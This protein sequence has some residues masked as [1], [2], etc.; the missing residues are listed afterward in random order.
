M[1]EKY[2]ELYKFFN[3]NALTDLDEQQFYDAYSGESKYLDIYRFML[4]NNMTD[5]GPESF[6]DSYFKKKSEVPEIPSTALSTPQDQEQPTDSVYQGTQLTSRDNTILDSI[7]R[8]ELDLLPHLSDSLWNDRQLAKIDNMESLDKPVKP[9]LIEVAKNIK[10]ESPYTAKALGLISSIPIVGEF[11]DDVSREV[12]AGVT[13]DGTTVEQNMGI[14]YKMLASEDVTMRDVDILLSDEKRRAEFEEKYGKSD[15]QI[16][17]EKMIAEDDSWSSNLLYYIQNPELGA[18]QAFRSQAALL[19]TK[20][21][22]AFGSVVAASMAAG[23]AI[24]AGL[25]GT[26]SAGVLALPGAAGGA[27]VGGAGSIIPAYALANGINELSLSFSDMIGLELDRLGL[28]RTEENILRVLNSDESRRNILRDSGTRGLAITMVDVL[29]GKFAEGVT[30]KMLEKGTRI[31]PTVG[32]GL[33]IEGTAGGVGEATARGLVGQELT[34]SDILA[35]A[36]GE[37]GGFVASG[38]APLIDAYSKRA[39]LRRSG[40]IPNGKAA[41]SYFVGDNEVTAE[42]FVETIISANEEQL[43]N[44]NIRVENDPAMSNFVQDR[45][46][47]EGIKSTIDSSIS[48]ED[49]NDIA[50]LEM[51]KAKVMSNIK[52]GEDAYKHGEITKK[53]VE[54]IDNQILEIL[55]KYDKPQEDKTISQDDV[56]SEQ[57]AEVQ[58]MEERRV[59]RDAAQQEA[60]EER[61]RQ[62]EEEGRVDEAEDLEPA[63]ER[64]SLVY[65]TDEARKAAREAAPAT[66]T[67]AVS[68]N[69]GQTYEIEYGAEGQ[70]KKVQG[71]LVQEGNKVSLESFDG[72]QIIELGSNDEVADASVKSLGLSPVSPPVVANNDGSFVVNGKTFVNPNENASDAITRNDDGDVVNVQLQ[73]EDGKRR[74]FRGTNADAIAYEIALAQM[75]TET[76][77][78]QLE[79]L[80]NEDEGTKEAFDKAR[81]SEQD[82]TQEADT[83]TQQD[84]QATPEQPVTEEGK[85]WFEE[86]RRAKE[87]AE[88]VKKE[89]SKQTEQKAVADA[90]RNKKV[91]LKQFPLVRDKRTGKL[92]RRVGGPFTFEGNKNL[93]R[94]VPDGKPLFVDESGTYRPSETEQNDMT[95]V[96]SSESLFETIVD[97]KKATETKKPT[98][99]KTESQREV[100]QSQ[101][102]IESIELEIEDVQQEID[103]EKGNYKEAMAGF[104][105]RIA[106]IRANKE[107]SKEEKQEAIDDIKEGEMVDYKDD[108]DGII[109]SYKDDISRLKKDLAAEK[110]RLKKL[111]GPQ[112][113]QQSGTREGT[114]D[115]DANQKRRVVKAKSMKDLLKI[116]MELFGLD[117]EKALYA[118]IIAD[119]MIGA[120]AIRSGKSKAQVYNSISWTDTED[121]TKSNDHASVQYQE[122]LTNIASGNQRLMLFDS[123]EFQQFVR[124]GRVTVGEKSISDFDGSVVF[125][126]PDGMFA[127][128]ITSNGREVVKGEGG[129][130]YP[131]VFS[132]ENYF[133]ASTKGTTTTLVNT[134][135]EAARRST[136]GKVRFALT[137]GTLTKVFS[138]TN[139]SRGIVQLFAEKALNAKIPLAQQLFKNAL[140]EANYKVGYKS[141][142][143]ITAQGKRLIDA[144]KA[145]ENLTSEQK[146]SKIKEIKSD[147]ANAYRERIPYKLGADIKKSM[148][149][150]DMIA[151]ILDKLDPDNSSFDDR[152]WFTEKLIGNIVDSINAKKNEA[153][154]QY[155]AN[156]FSDFSGLESVIATNTKSYTKLNIKDVQSAIARSIQEKFINQ[157]Y[158]DGAQ[159]GVTYAVIEVDVNP[160]G[161]TFRAVDTKAE[162]RRSHDSYPFAVETVNGAKPV[163]HLLSDAK[164]YYDVA[165]E[166]G[167]NAPVGKHSKTLY[168]TSGLSKVLEFYHNKTM[169]LAQ[170][171]KYEDNSGTT[172]VAT[173]TGSYTKAAKKL[174][175]SNPES[176]L[177]YGA[178]L[179][180]G[181][182]AMSD[183]FG[184][185]VDSYEPNPERWKGRR[186]ATFAGQA[187]I[188]K[189]YD[190]IVSLNVLNVVPKFI[191][192]RIVTDIYNKLNN[193]GKAYISARKFKGDVANAKNSVKGDEHNSLVITR[194]QGGQDVE[195][196]QKGFDGDEL[197]NYIQGLL[198]DKVEVKKDNS[199]GASGVVITR[200]SDE[201]VT[202][203]SILFQDARAA[204]VIEDMKAV[205]YAI[206]NPDVTS[207]LHELSHLFE[208]Y[209]TDE[210][211]QAVLDW[212][213]HEEWSRDTSEAFADGF[214]RFLFQGPSEKIPEL[215]NVFQKFKQWVMEIY[216]GIKNSPMSRELNEPMTRIYESMV[217]AAEPTNVTHDATNEAPFETRQ[218][219]WFQNTMDTLNIR[220]AE[221]YW[222]IFMLQDDIERFR[223]KLPKRQNFKAAED[224]MHGRTRE[225]IV[226]MEKILDQAVDLMKRYKLDSFDVGQYLLALHA[227]ER[228]EKI[229]FDQV[230]KGIEEPNEAG[231]GM[232]TEEARRILS[233]LRLNPEKL[234][235]L[236][237][238][239]SLIRKIQDQTR[240]NLVAYGLEPEGRVASWSEMFSEYIP[241]H[242]FALDEMNTLELESETG[243]PNG[244]TGLH[245]ASPIVKKAK[246]RT[247]TAVNP[248]ATVV[249]QAQ[250]VIVAGEKNRALTAMFNLIN[251]NPNEEFWRIT[252]KEKGDHTVAV[253]ING[254]KVYMYFE[255]KDYAKTI[256]NTG[257]EK[258]SFISKMLRATNTWLRRA[259]TTLDPEFAITNFARDIQSAVINALSETDV[260]DLDGVKLAKGIMKRTTGKNGTLRALL[261]HNRG[262]TSG[263]DKM[264]TYINEFEMLGGKTGWSHVM[265]LEQIADDLKYKLDELS[266]SR[267]IMKRAGTPL[268]FVTKL[269]EDVNDAFENSIRL[270]SYITAVESGVSKE[271]AALLAKNITVNFNRSGEMGP[272]LNSLYLFFNASVQGTVRLGKS[273]GSIKPPKKPD[274]ADRTTWER[275]NNAQKVVMALTVFN[276]MLTAVNMALSDE[277]EDGELIYNKIPDYERERNLI[278]MYDGK[279]YLK[280]PM[281]YG[282]SVF[283]NFGESLTNYSLGGRTLDHSLAFM[284]SSVIGS[285]SPISFGQSE[286][287]T[288]LAL[289][290]VAPTSLKSLAEIALNES[291]YGSSIY[292]EQL[293]FMAPQSEASMG[294]YSPKSVQDF[295]NWMNEVNGGTKYRSSGMMTDINP[296]AAWHILQYYIGGTGKF[297]T[298][299]GGLI[300]N[301]QGLA[302]SGEWAKMA[303]NQIPFVRKL[304]GSQ[305]KYYD[306]DL[307]RENTNMVRSL[308]AEY[309]DPESRVDDLSIYKNIKPLS[310]LNKEIEKRLKQLRKKREEYSQLDNYTERVNKTHEIEEIQ[311][312]LMM[313]FN[314]KYDE[315]RKD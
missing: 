243:S 57:E 136:N 34:P 177:D 179:G 188:D 56:V 236:N 216:Q 238:I 77:E 22:E 217:N 49:A 155:F 165:N 205:I 91:N 7:D 161:D 184:Y 195:V 294:F 108:Y 276:G 43:Q 147:E 204:I 247:T 304:Y 40:K 142:E 5:L 45:F 135:N 235:R 258:L 260:P 126:S 286:T 17:Y 32:A 6:Y 119:R 282:Y 256:K 137:T 244:G 241:L 218:R 193:G 170:D 115:K 293:P 38:G 231:S 153:A 194:R 213:G 111:Q 30:I 261:N 124:D 307:Y 246:G 207:P 44:M 290:S 171:G 254:E 314:M 308:M 109:D 279:N 291:Y 105:K 121:P 287:L 53:R 123:E 220:I 4:S 8:D 94:Y 266:R 134:L 219:T 190:G 26:P 186:P 164:N 239:K 24:G 283:A 310:D 42:Q 259:Y 133:W 86:Q 12:F 55:S 51:E 160:N 312:R 222:R 87:T 234:R 145:D 129:V 303:P 268:K 148:S 200:K 66:R 183:V 281:P 9:F 50:E 209:L 249:H 25:F 180:L 201:D 192:D 267:L 230:E 76:V 19:N 10:E 36:F 69:I 63:K 151:A 255:N 82:A 173:T 104:K 248:L 14:I 212:A 157:L 62:L 39:D 149:L 158:E 47:M 289:K 98:Q 156:F 197:V 223:K 125:H 228:N 269:I 60:I 103:I 175:E 15:E 113:L 185:D 163:V 41:P 11:I 210:E 83:D 79:T 52:T 202:D 101:E 132:E 264:T 278:F 68:E 31:L 106:E 73:T 150:E 225:R 71:T 245:V 84:Q 80:E 102:N 29:G 237:E 315:L 167:K 198:G 122:T 141:K 295:F 58:L 130:L 211:R 265:P 61:K 199:F 97:G 262:M 251:D 117:R 263:D 107:M 27:A 280:V 85:E 65:P 300:T 131:L 3:E 162:G 221:K 214:E 172:Q 306:Y 89:E 54:E 168:P 311:R 159:S 285:F 72:K 139:A 114:Q 272:L 271:D 35:E 100:E 288:G 181:T 196:F 20:A 48:P 95:G 174:A 191:R 229:F 18:Q 110:R 81:A 93:Y 33:A 1:N 313:H 75:D 143:V 242:G 226:R 176:V 37:V 127:G 178:G 274:G 154:S 253:R 215:D 99:P 270:S 144:V 275:I 112:V 2:K 118:A 140:Y 250:A 292:R 67:N 296:D 227:E 28:E 189:R 299:T 59:I 88:K 116:N 70:K 298:K 21:A 252:S 240:K 273:L 16:E 297:V 74:T 301:V 90:P 305:S 152:K 232:T 120:M 92:Y 78:Q 284:A 46:T 224:A 13:V 233:E 203:Q 169:A 309:K 128:A 277:D 23:G 138:N 182:D 206:N 166:S 187:D 64:V 208:H 96:I 302:S 146:K 257:V